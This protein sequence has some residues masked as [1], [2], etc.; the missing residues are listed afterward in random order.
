MAAM[1]LTSRCAVGLREG[2]TVD[3]TGLETWPRGLSPEL[4][5]LGNEG[6]LSFEGLTQ[7][8]LF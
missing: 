8:A 4:G 2:V 1:M 3:Y 7:R 6:L 5:T